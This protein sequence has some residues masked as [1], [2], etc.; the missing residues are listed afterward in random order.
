[1]LLEHPR[2]PCWVTGEGAAADLGMSHRGMM[3]RLEKPA[4]QQKRLCRMNSLPRR[5][6]SW[7][8]GGSRGP[9]ESVSD[10]SYVPRHSVAVAEVAN[11]RAWTL[12]RQSQFS[13]LYLCYGFCG[14]V[15]TPI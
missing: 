4:Q 11:L 1:M 10:I 3:R 14:F 6:S 15:N 12:G 9:G 2:S 13:L 5:L 8:D 7:K